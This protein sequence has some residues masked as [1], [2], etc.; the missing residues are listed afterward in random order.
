MLGIGVGVATGTDAGAGV[1][2]AAGETLMLTVA[3]L[4]AAEPSVA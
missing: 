2:M 1:G 3:V 4:P